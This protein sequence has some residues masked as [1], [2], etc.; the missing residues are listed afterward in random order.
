[1]SSPTASEPSTA[2]ANSFEGGPLSPG[3]S[4]SSKMFMK[5]H[6]SVP[7][8]FFDHQV[9]FLP[10]PLEPSNRP[11]ISQDEKGERLLQSIW[12]TT[13]EDQWPSLPTQLASIFDDPNLNRCRFGS[14]L[15]RPEFSPKFREKCDFLILVLG[16]P[17]ERSTDLSDFYQEDVLAMSHVA[18]WRQLPLLVL[19]PTFS[20]CLDTLPLILFTV[21]AKL[22]L[23][24]IISP[25]VVFS[26]HGCEQENGED[27]FLRTSTRGSYVSDGIKF[28]GT[29]GSVLRS[30]WDREAS[31]ILRSKSSRN[32][33]IPDWLVVLNCC[34]ATKVSKMSELELLKLLCQDVTPKMYRQGIEKRK[35][36][37][38][39]RAESKNYTEEEEEEEEEENEETEETEEDDEDYDADEIFGTPDGFAHERLFKKMGEDL[40]KGYDSEMCPT[41]EELTEIRASIGRFEFPTE[42]LFSQNSRVIAAFKALI[43]AHSLDFYMNRE[44]ILPISFGPLPCSGLLHYI[45]YD[46]LRADFEDGSIKLRD[47]EDETGESTTSSA[48]SS[49]LEREESVRTQPALVASEEFT[50]GCQLADECLDRFTRL[51]V[52]LSTFCEHD[53]LLVKAR[54]N[55]I[56]SN[57]QKSQPSAEA[58]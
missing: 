56:Y 49:E 34:H 10:S 53:L 6:P 40:M 46:E 9:A 27:F 45:F 44:G 42:I 8:F 29:P 32:I 18:Y 14:N 15:R 35:K 19:G 2:A 22:Q 4:L 54:S 23:K 48:F 3:F 58:Q 12:F 39:L 52:L 7:V 47:E 13:T 16:E 21:S 41:D 24:E 30:W 38:K 28:D 57:N 50:G 43:G 37:E 11:N 51:F 17:K 5:D 25:L 36:I 20:C 33:A 55:K 31:P 26:G 1:M